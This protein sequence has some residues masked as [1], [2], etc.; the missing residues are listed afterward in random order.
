MVEGIERSRSCNDA[1]LPITKELLNSILSILPC[2]CSSQSQ[3]SLF[4]SVFSLAFH[5]MLRVG[6]LTVGSECAKH[7][8]LTVNNVSAS[9][10]ILEIY[11]AT[12]KTDQFGSGTILQIYPQENQEICPVVHFLIT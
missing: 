12:S 10:V 4:K 11:L 7:Q 5:D 3:C 8:T 1:I 6:E 9:N 2:I